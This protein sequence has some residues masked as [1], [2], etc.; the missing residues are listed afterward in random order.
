MSTF[1]KLAGDTALYGIST[2][3]GRM[4][5][6]VLVPL[7]TY[8]FPQP[9]QLASNVELYSYVAVLLTIYTLGLETAFFRFAARK[10]GEQTADERQR[11]FND[12]LS[13]VMLVTG[14]FTLL[15]ILLTP[16]LTVWLNYPGQQT[17]IVWVALIVAI[18]AIV[19][20]PF[21]RLRV[22]NKARQFVQAKVVS[23]VLVVF[24]NVFFL[25]ICRDIYAG[26]YLSALRPAIALFYNP[27][28]GPGYIFLAN[29]LGNAAYFVMLR[30]AFRGF[31]FRIDR[32]ETGVLLAYAF[33]IMLTGLAA[34]INN[35]TDRAFLRHYLPEGFYEG[36][37]SADALG[38]YGNCLKLSVFMALAIQSFKFA[39]DPFFFSQA[40]DK[41]A[42]DLLARVTK[43]F[44]IVCLFIW[45]GVS[46]NL[47]VIGLLV[48]KRY[49]S[50]L[51]VVPLL[52]LANLFLGVYYNIAFWFKLSDKTSFGTLITVVGAV[53]TV[54]GNIVL[55]PLLGYMG[56]AVAFLASSFVMMAMCYVLGEKYYPVPYDVK[57][58]AGYV[59]GSGLLIFLTLRFPIDNLW[60]AIPIHLALFGLFTLTVLFVERNTLRPILTRFR[61]RR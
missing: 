54:V 46:L 43:W 6:F 7:Q 59:L 18:D 19:A 1:K 42:P 34:V 33:P 51:G 55:I 47:D 37:S 5:N 28:I 2:I 53:I 21:A 4:L 17:F 61:N 30:D 27:A 60:L 40:E 22:E 44:L 26:K 48:S 11:V 16:Q 50:G 38:I 39:A 56:C 15:I 41:N 3:L 9:G 35:M 58:A 32:A 8:V 14:V 25:I 31:R 10:K 57:S 52:L 36:I 49:R 29:L 12:T 20:I 45:V 24:L 23:I 13:I